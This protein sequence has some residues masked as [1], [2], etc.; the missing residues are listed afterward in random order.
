[1]GMILNFCK[2]SGKQLPFLH[3]FNYGILKDA[4]F[5]I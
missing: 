1:M 4:T 3:S 5:I 2:L